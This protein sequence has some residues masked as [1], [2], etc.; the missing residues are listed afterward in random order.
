M[1]TAPA[2]Q[3]RMR[4][5]GRIEKGYDADFCVFA[6]DETFLVDPARLHH[7]NALTPYAGQRLTG[8]VRST[9]LR[10]RPIDIDAEPRGRLLTRGES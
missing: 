4:R 5:K 10:G 9:W 7:K 1:A 3:T 2:E 8:V 6:P